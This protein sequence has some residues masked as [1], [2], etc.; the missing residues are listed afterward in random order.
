MQNILLL[1]LSMLVGGV[2]TSYLTLNS[3]L[4]KEVGSDL[5]ANLPYFVL[6]LLVTLCMLFILDS[7]VPFVKLTEV[8]WYYLTAGLFAG[9][10]LYAT[11]L[12]IGSV[13]PDKFFVA[14]VSGQLIISV[15]L[16][17]FGW[18]G[19]EQVEVDWRKV[20][21]IALAIS[22]AVLVSWK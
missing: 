7:P 12:L 11:T 5:L 3:L 16:T 4:S 13:G 8:P 19:T 14:S 1:L 17:H 10:A 22:G 18:L 6:A 9:A 21:G 20:L 15:A 2:V